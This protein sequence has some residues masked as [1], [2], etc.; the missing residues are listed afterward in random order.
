MWIRVFCNVLVLHCIAF[1]FELIY[2]KICYPTTW[3]GFVSSLILAPSYYC[4]ACRTVSYE[5]TRFVAYNYY[6]LFGCFGHYI[7]CKIKNI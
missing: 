4:I 1:S 2:Q 7:Y 3:Y 5:I 6:I